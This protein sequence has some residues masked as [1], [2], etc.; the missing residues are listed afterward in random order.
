M[1][2]PEASRGRAK[3]DPEVRGPAIGWIAHILQGERPLFFTLGK[4]LRGSISREARA[5][6]RR[7]SSGPSALKPEGRHHPFVA[8]DLLLTGEGGAPVGRTARED[9]IP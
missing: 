8:W 1:P 5:P 6:A 9:R 3:P 7:N 4:G 2:S